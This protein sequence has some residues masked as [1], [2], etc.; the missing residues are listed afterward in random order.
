MTHRYPRNKKSP[1]WGAFPKPAPVGGLL[2][3]Q[4]GPDCRTKAW[5]V[6]TIGADLIITD[7]DDPCQLWVGFFKDCPAI[8]AA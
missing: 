7:E 8:G 3:V 4:G 5:V 2:G 6:I 1:P